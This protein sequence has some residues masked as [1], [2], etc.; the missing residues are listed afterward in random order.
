MAADTIAPAHTWLYHALVLSSEISIRRSPRPLANPVRDKIGMGMFL[1]RATEA[2]KQHSCTL[3]LVYRLQIRTH[4]G[5]H[6]RTWPCATILSRRDPSSISPC[7]TSSTVLLPPKNILLHA[8]RSSHD[9]TSTTSARTPA[10]ES[11]PHP[12]LAPAPR[13]GFRPDHPTPSSTSGLLRPQR[14]PAPRGPH[15]DNA[16]RHSQRA[17]PPVLHSDLGDL[18]ASPLLLLPPQLA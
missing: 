12:T 4:M 8:H 9:N 18:T 2:A 14:F 6:R 16:H 10:F 5:D 3:N 15:D 17:R 13:L 11:S 1:N 7:T